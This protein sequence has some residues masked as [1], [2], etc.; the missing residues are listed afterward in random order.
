MRSSLR[1]PYPHP[2]R[3]RLRGRFRSVGL[4]SLLLLS[5]CPHPHRCRLRGRLRSLGLDSP[6]PL[7]LRRSAQCWVAAC[8]W[9]AAGLPR[10][11]ASCSAAAAYEGCPGRIAHVHA[12]PTGSLAWPSP[13][14][15]CV[16]SDSS[17]D[18]LPDRLPGVSI[19][20][21]QVRGLRFN[22]FA[23]Q[24]VAAALPLITLI[25]D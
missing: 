20:L 1:R 18:R 21:H 11:S 5:L 2:P 16:G 8:G 15:R 12:A 10:L 25:I 9:P 23:I 14:T 24:S 4:D 17:A 19:A 6:L 22:A 7:S 13:S 3:R